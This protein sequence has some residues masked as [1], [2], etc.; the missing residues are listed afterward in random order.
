MSI[1]PSPELRS[2]FE[3]ALKQ[4]ES[5]TGTN[6]VQHQV[7]NKLLACESIESIVDIL[8]KHWQPRTLRTSLG[9]YSTLMKWIKRTVHV[10]QSLST[11]SMV[12]DGVSSVCGYF[13]SASILHNDIMFLQAFAPAKAVFAAIALLLSVRFFP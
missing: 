1:H 13:C 10:L 5:R 8:Q 12:V 3:D 4:F 6:L 7:F 9:D 11:N 2:L